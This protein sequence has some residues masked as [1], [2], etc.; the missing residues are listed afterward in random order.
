[1]RIVDVNVCSPILNIADHWADLAGRAP[2]NVFMNPVALNVAHETSFAK[3]HVLLAWDR[4]AEPKK[5]VGLWAL[6]DVSTTALWPTFL[7]GPPYNY[8]FLS[9]PVVDHAYMDEVMP[10]FFDAIE[11]HPSLPNVIRLRY[12]DGDSEIYEPMRKALAARGSHSLVLSQRTRP[13]VTTEFGLKTSGST[14]KKMRQDWNRLS[15]LGSVDVVNDRAPAQVR[16][17]FEIF[18]L[19]EAESWKGARGTALLCS[20]KDA[21]FTRHFVS[22]LAAQQNASVALLRVDGQPVAAQV[23]LYSAAMAYTWKT[24]FDSEYAKYSPGALLVDRVTEMLFAS[25]QVKAIESCSPEG[26]FMANMWDGRRQTV[27]LL[28]DVGARKSLSFD[29]TAFGERGYAQL[30]GLRNKLRS[31]WSGQSKKKGVAASR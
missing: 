5:L 25:G 17:A 2:A 18:L 8:A 1:M 30:R 10:A 21:A 23:L 20:T 11:Q 28:V 27:D 26:S 6:A 19:M 4:S 14:R 13:F 22:N 12:L 9:G 7:A 31:V 15:S 16:E 24:A 29:M 3:V